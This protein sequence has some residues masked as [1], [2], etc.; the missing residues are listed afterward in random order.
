MAVHKTAQRQFKPIG[1]H[2]RDTTISTVTTLT[3]PA[4]ADAILIQCL[5]RDVR[6]VLTGADP[7]AST[8]FIMFTGDA[9][10]LIHT[11][12]LKVIETAASASIEYQWGVMTDA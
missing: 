7:T 10:Q 8:G 12:S 2:D 9:P 4:G 3:A 11:K 1:N 5:T 6:Y